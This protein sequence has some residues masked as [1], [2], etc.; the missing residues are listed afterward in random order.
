VIIE[1]FGKRLQWDKKV[2]AAPPLF[3]AFPRPRGVAS[4]VEAK[5]EEIY[6]LPSEGLIAASRPSDPSFKEIKMSD[7]IKRTL[8]LFKIFEQLILV[9]NFQSPMTWAMVGANE[10]V[11]KGKLEF[12]LDAE[13]DLSERSKVTVLEGR[14]KDLR[15]PINL[16]VTD[17]EG[18]TANILF[19]KDRM[20][21][22][23]LREIGQS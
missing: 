17:K 23:I 9:Q 2:K 13:A 1:V 14:A 15:F 19:E 22:P 18:R 3:L 7:D 16:F 5:I 11:L 12:L 10:A 6:H 4:I 21:E 8:A 20:D